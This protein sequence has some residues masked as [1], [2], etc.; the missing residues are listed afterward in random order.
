[1]KFY[2]GFSLASGASHLN[3]LK[4]GVAAA[5]FRLKRFKIN[6]ELT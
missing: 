5:I 3:T 4:S 2:D 1:M 6:Q